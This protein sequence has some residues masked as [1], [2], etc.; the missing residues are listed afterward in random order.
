M[1]LKGFP[2]PADYKITLYDHAVDT[3]ATYWG[4]PA[5][6]MNF[7]A[8][9]LT[10]NRRIEVLYIKAGANPSVEPS[11]EI[12]FIEKDRQGEP[13]LT[14]LVFFAGL[15]SAALPQPGD[16]YLLATLKPFSHRDIFRFSTIA[17]GVSGDTH[18]NAPNDFALWQNYPNPFNAATI[19]SFVVPNRSAVKVEIF[20]L[21][22]QR[23]KTLV[24]E[25]LAAGVY[26]KIWDGK[27]D[28]QK[29]AASGIYFYRLTSRTVVQQR[30]MI[31]LR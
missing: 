22:G 13:M 6:P 30:K 7:T 10:E 20:D 27:S 15:P 31:L 2:Y 21:M 4:A 19:I 18:L 1:I 25:V 3:S 28:G 14:W 29:D 26:Q 9:N 23:V 17:T 24:D 5:T 16:E 11:D 8:T 12:Y